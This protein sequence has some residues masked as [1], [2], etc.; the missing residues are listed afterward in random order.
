MCITHYNLPLDI[1]AISIKFIFLK[2]F[3]MM[4]LKQGPYCPDN[5]QLHGVNRPCYFHKV[6]TIRY[7]FILSR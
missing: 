1:L 2:G 5:T 6:T 3:Q 7:K 4:L